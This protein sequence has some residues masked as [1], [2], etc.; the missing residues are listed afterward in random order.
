MLLTSTSWPRG[1]FL[2]LFSVN[3]SNPLQP[4]FKLNISPPFLRWSSV[5]YQPLQQ[6]QPV[7][8]QVLPALADHN[9]VCVVIGISEKALIGQR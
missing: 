8:Q 5:V 2:E 7:S 4:V 9:Q 3:D 1:R 6:V